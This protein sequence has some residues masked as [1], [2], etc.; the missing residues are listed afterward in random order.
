MKTWWRSRKRYQRNLIRLAV[1]YV[2]LWSI[3]ALLAPTLERK[4]AEMRARN[5]QPSVQASEATPKPVKSTPRSTQVGDRVGLQPLG[6]AGNSVVVWKSYDAQERGS[7][8]AKANA[9]ILLMLPH[10]SC[11]VDPGTDASFALPVNPKK[12]LS[13]A[14][15]EADPNYSSTLVE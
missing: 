13:T 10:V 14:G 1:V 15:G 4:T 2:I 8:L 11:K 3:A 7:N 9:S 6:D 12:N 5:P